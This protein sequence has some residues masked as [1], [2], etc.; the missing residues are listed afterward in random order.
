MTSTP[1]R[2]SVVLDSTDPHGIAGFWEQALGYRRAADLGTFL[3]LAPDEPGGGPV[4]VLQRVE[5][6][7]AGRRM[8]LDLHPADAGVHVRLLE[9][10]GA[11]R[12]GPPVTE[13]QATLG[14]WWQVMT[15]PQ[16]NTFCVVADPPQPPPDPTKEST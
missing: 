15:D 6:E 1:V 3:V 16:G 10:L 14:V 11:T 13:L 9:G 12:V 5:Q 2:M 7:P 4:V 8:H